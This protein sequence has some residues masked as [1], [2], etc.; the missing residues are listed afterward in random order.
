MFLIREQ[1]FANALRLSKIHITFIFRS[2]CMYIYI[3]IYI[4]I[5]TQR[6]EN[7]S[8]D[9]YFTY[10]YIYIYIYKYIYLRYTIQNNS[11][12]F[13]VWVI[14]D[15]HMYGVPLGVKNIFL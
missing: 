7:K 14:L 4:Y 5:Y 12:T 3:Y 13:C 9:V 2:L 15:P 10:I 11:Y 1:K 8:N 6:S